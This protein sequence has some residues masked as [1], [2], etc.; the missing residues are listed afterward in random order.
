MSTIDVK[1]VKKIVQDVLGELRGSET[2]KGERKLSQPEVQGSRVL[3]LFHA[4]VRKLDEALEQTRLIEEVAGK[5]G[6]FTGESARQ[7]V[8]GADVKEGAGS[9]C[10]LDTVRP[11]GLEKVL[12]RADILVLPT[13]CLMV[14]AKV[15][16]LVC[17][18]EE[19]M[20]VF[21]ALLMGKKILASNDGFLI[22]DILANDNIRGEIDRILNKLEGFGITFCETG[23]LSAVFRK[24]ATSDESKADETPSES[25]PEQSGAPGYRLIT[26]NIVNAAV[27][28][29]ETTIR[30]APG[31]KVTPLARDLAREYGIKIVKR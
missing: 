2:V 5:S 14:A 4:G 12:E 15:A 10:I 29:K 24:L 20:L 8:C 13:L 25:T 3:I 21:R 17:D 28:N 1:D 6:V 16:N 9:A 18:D 11:D 31:G 19:S 22:C 26:A 23:Q 7:W 30:L 27:D